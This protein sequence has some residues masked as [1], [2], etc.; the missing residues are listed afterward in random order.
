M[1][2]S[3]NDLKDI[4]EETF[5]ANQ[6]IIQNYFENLSG[7]Q[8][9]LR[10]IGLTYSSF[11][12]KVFAEP[13]EMVKIQANYLNFLDKQQ[14]LFL[15]MFNRKDGEAYS[16]VIEPRHEDKR[17]KAPEWKDQPFF[18]YIKQSYLLVTEFMQKSVNDVDMEEGRKRKLSFYMNHYID[19]L[20]PSNF[21]A[22]NPEVIQLAQET[23]GESLKQGYKNLLTDVKKG[24][25]TQ[26]D[27]TAFEVGKNLAITPG[28]VV[29]Q[30]EL[31]QLIQY[32]PA[33]KKV[34]E[35]PLLIIPPWIN[36][37]YILDLQPENSFARFMV[38]KGFTVFMISW[39]NPTPFMRNTSFD[40]YVEKGILRS[41]EVIQSITNGKKVNM[42][43]YCLG[44]TL[45]GTA[46]AVMYAQKNIS[47]QSATFLASMLDFSDVG[48][49][50]DV[51][52][53]ALVRKLER[54]ELQKQGVM[55]GHDMERAFNLIRANDLIWNYVVNNY[56]KGKKP[57]AFDVL[58]W[59]NDNTN[60]PAKMYSY[61]LR[62]M[63]LGNKLSRKNALRMCDTPIDLGQIDIPTFIVATREDH[64]SPPQ[65]AFTTTELLSG[66]VEFVLGDSGHV[67]GIANPPS[68]KKYGYSRFGKLG[69]GY[70]KWK[71]TSKHFEGSWWTPWSEWLASHSGK[72]INAPAKE[73]NKEY[74]II[75]PAPGTY[76]REKCSHCFPDN[77]H[78][79]NHAHS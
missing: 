29:Y 54:G 4:F 32:K 10:D 69:Y 33:G 77:A 58:F 49:M 37:Y 63:V 50:G 64:I 19:A 31:I 6:K 27:E 52:D 76:V 42:L 34:Y 12:S 3:E 61:Y 15:S 45:L 70:E 2:E 38:E 25:I 78:E 20:S 59:T 47:A 75:E 57:T 18:D 67:M 35:N 74:K 11:A 5:R 62:E 17:F 1:K 48:P 79:K 16:P 51:I 44:G 22:T 72:K 53:Q 13:E 43:G 68:R 26:M 41:A 39:K 71:E 40:D 30:N 14:K 28:A 66:P 23:K 60:L 9:D 8:H 21:A 24:R 56:L 36:K 65:T 55:H 46:L 73:G 7:Y